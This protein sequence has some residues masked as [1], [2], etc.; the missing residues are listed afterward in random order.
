ML[1]LERDPVSRDHDIPVRQIAILLLALPKRTHRALLGQLS[2]LD[3]QRVVEKIDALGEVDP[4][5]QYRVLSVMREQLHR[6][7]KSVESVESEIQDEILIGRARLAKKRSLSLA[8][9]REPVGTSGR[10]TSASH[11][12]DPRDEAS[13][14]SGLQDS[15]GPMDFLLR[16]HTNDA[17]RLLHGE[18]PQTIAVVLS[19]IEPHT[20]A[21]LLP[22]MPE[23]LQA[24]TLSRLA[25]LGE[26]PPETVQEIAAHLRNRID[27]DSGRPLQMAPEMLQQLVDQLH[28]PVQPSEADTW[29]V[30]YDLQAER[31]KRRRHLPKDAAS[32]DHG[33]QVRSV[34]PPYATSGDSGDAERVD[35]FLLETDPKTLCRALGMVTTKQAFLV[36]CGLPNET[37][38]TILGLLPRRT[39]RKVRSDMR[40]VGQLQLSEID[41]AKRQ[42]SQIVMRITAESRSMVA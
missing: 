33:D 6:E 9:S 22:K 28:H 18:S 21:L 25:R 19:S 39:A 29:P 26:V 1:Q 40:R 2:P 42:V 15:A 5:E 27:A 7:T 37:A 8:R 30:S 3:K 4:M 12:S 31:L 32:G 23:H 10:P 24:E 34:G 36:L 17:A 13:T 14:Q 20:A 38:E 11:P 16:M 41:A 35:Q